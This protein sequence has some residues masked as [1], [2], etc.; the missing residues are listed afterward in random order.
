MVPGFLQCLIIETHSNPR[1][2]GGDPEGGGGAA[3]S[4]GSCGQQSDPGWG[5]RVQL[6]QTGTGSVH[7]CVEGVSACGCECAPSRWTW[8]YSAQL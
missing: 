1:R 5:Q 7:M 3:V 2:S 4:S 8:V 6:L